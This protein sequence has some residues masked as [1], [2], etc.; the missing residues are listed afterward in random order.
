MEQ[1]PISELRYFVER[2][3]ELSKQAYAA[4]KPQVDALINSKTTDN[5]QIEQLLDLL[6][7]FCSDSQ[8]LLLYKKLCRYYW[9]L[10]PEATARYINYYREMWDNESDKIEENE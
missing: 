2:L 1:N 3:N 10:N 6:L 4:Y 7:D 9:E 5:Q 8:M